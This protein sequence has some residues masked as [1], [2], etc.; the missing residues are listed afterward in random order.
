MFF[1]I[2]VW[3]D[4]DVYKNTQTFNVDDNKYPIEKVRSLLE[5]N[6]IISLNYHP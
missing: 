5:E 3:S 4:I 1:L 6:G 2:A